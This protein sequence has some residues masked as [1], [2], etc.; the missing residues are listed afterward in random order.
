MACCGT[1]PLACVVGV[2]WWVGNV[3]CVAHTVTCL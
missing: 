2:V 3:G 1:R